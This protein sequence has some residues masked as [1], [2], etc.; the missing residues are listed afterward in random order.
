MADGCRLAAR[1]WLPDDAEADP[2]PAILEYI[3][4]RKNDFTAQR[5]ALMH[6]WFAGHGYAAVRVDLRGSGDSDGLLLGE[7]LPQEQDDAVEVLSWLAEQPWCTGRVGIIGKSWGGFNGLQIA[8]RRPP[9]L[10]A[11][12]SVCSTDDRYAD[13]V[14]Y[15]GGCV[16]GSDALGWGS[17][18]LAFNARP[19]DPAVVGERWRD[20]WLERLERTPPFAEEWLSHQ[21]RDAFWRHGSVCE[22]FSAIECP[23][24][25]VGGWADPY[26]NAVLRF[27]AGYPGPRK[28]LIGPWA[29]T[30]PHQGAPGPAI[31]FLQECLRWWDEWLKGAETGITDEPLLR[32]WM[33][34]WTPPS[35]TCAERP[36]CW[37]AEPDWPSPRIETRVLPLAGGSPGVGAGYIRP[38]HGGTDSGRWDITGSQL[39]GLEGGS[40]IPFG[41]PGELPPDQRGEDGLSLCFDTAPLGEPVEILGFPEVVLEVAADRPLA[42]A[43]A[44]LCDVAPDGSSLLV[45]RGLLN[46]AHRDGHEAPSPLE[47]GRRYEVG[48]RLSAIAHA[49][50][51]GHRIRVA[52]SP[53]YW[54][55]AWPSPEVVTLTVFAGRL[56]L[57][58]RPTGSADDGP[59]PF[60]PPEAAPPLP[61]ERLG[62]MPPAGRRIVRDLGAGS[63]ELVAQL[64]ASG[65]VRLLGVEIE[66]EGSDRFTIREGDP[67]SARAESRWRIGIGRD[68]WRTRVETFST[69]TADREAFLVTNEVR[70][71][72]GDGQVFARTWS[73]SIPRDHV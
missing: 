44:R 35:A 50:P 68:G 42:L 4:Y 65:R 46:L 62:E 19:P 1:I 72:E 13:D 17:V 61:V 23:V 58:V 66:D 22:D 32:V 70:A 51:A 39:C 49:F 11:V 2:V 21:R 29:H 41:N 56:E 26:R 30:Y 5:D 20:L 27:L 55:W 9:E 71:Y 15:M 45:T 34:D 31:G 6:P 47:P 52:I 69:L 28:G 38:P 33:Q 57:P 64:P 37:V 67:L 25:M 10:G 48:V 63:A 3:P 53:T 18:M 7:Y 8:A 40:W 73:A 59:A 54:P 24:Y 14:H 60:E 16:L 43:C 12:V 36:G